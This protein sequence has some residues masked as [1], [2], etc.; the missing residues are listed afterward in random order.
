MSKREDYLFESVML[1][2]LVLIGCI[3]WIGYCAD[4]R[5]DETLRV[6]IPAPT[7]TNPGSAT[8]SLTITVEGQQ[9]AILS[10]PAVGE[11][12]VTVPDQQPA[13]WEWD[14]VAHNAVGSTSSENGPQVRRGQ[15]SWDLS[16]NEIVDLPDLG[17]LLRSGDW[18]LT[19]MGALLR[20]LG[21]LCP[22]SSP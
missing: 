21:V 20:A 11:V 9:V 10:K 15:C 5:A 2:G 13:R 14:A 6:Q 3:A 12:E 16:Q 8:D 18:S 19:S 7:N 22:S 17:R 1:A 4:A